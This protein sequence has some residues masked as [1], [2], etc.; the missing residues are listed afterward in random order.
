VRY[1]PGT[2]VELAREL[3]KALNQIP[4]VQLLE[5]GKAGKNTSDALMRVTGRRLTG[6]PRGA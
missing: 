5:D 4:G 6:D 3:Q 2:V 1:K